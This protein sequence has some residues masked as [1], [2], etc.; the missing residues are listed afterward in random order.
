[1]DPTKPYGD[2][3]VGFNHDEFDE[4]QSRTRIVGAQKGLPNQKQLVRDRS[5]GSDFNRGRWMRFVD[6][7][8]LI[9][10]CWGWTW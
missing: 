8:G 4:Q 10:V 9:D 7:V 2:T 6:L 1:M 3:R 5:D